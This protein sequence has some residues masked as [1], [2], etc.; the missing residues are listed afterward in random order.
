MS[1]S[2]CLA[3][4]QPR[5][6][7]E[8]RLG[9]DDMGVAPRIVGF[10]QAMSFNYLCNFLYSQLFVTPSVPEVPLRGKTIIITGS[11]VGFEVPILRMCTDLV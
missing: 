3:L 7:Q 1:L 10:R 2:L 4:A 9:I 5:L 8:A 11:N 6:Y